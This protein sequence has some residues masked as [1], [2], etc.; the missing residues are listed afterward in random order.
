MFSREGEQK[1]AAKGYN[2]RQLGRKSH[3]P[4]LAMLAEM[5]FVSQDQYRVEQFLR[6]NASACGYRVASKK[7]E[8]LEFLSPGFSILI[9]EIYGRLSSRQ[10]NR[11]LPR[12]ARQKKP[13]KESGRSSAL[14]QIMCS[15]ALF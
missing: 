7:Y 9:R 1:G 3:H 5:P 11:V 10:K 15:L 12:S 2:P 13:A 6:G 14:K 8:N 4:I